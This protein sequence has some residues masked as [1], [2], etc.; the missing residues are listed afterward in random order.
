M[1]GNKLAHMYGALYGRQIRKI[2]D[3]ALKKNLRCVERRHVTE[4]P[5]LEI[6]NKTA[7]ARLSVLVS[8]T[9]GFEN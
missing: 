6:Q 8:Q 1:V 2:G 7:L 5:R 3:T 4:S 9:G